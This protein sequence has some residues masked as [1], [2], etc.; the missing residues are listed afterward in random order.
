MD[1]QQRLIELRK[2]YD[3][4]MMDSEIAPIL[5]VSR[6]SVLLYRKELGLKTKFTYQ[7]RRKLK[8]EDFEELFKKGYSDY[9]IADI[10]GI[11]HCTVFEFR[12]KN[13]Y[14]RESLRENKAIKIKD[15]DI[16]FI[17]GTLMGDSSMRKTSKTSNASLVC[18]HSPKQ[19]ELTEYIANRL[20][21]LGTRFSYSKRSTPDK[22][23]GKL[24]EEYRVTT[25]ANPELNK[26]YDLFY[27]DGKRTIPDFFLEKFNTESLA[28]LFMDD[29]YKQEVSYSL[30]TMAYSMEDLERF[31]KM[32]KD[33]FNIEVSIHKDH[34]IR[35]KNSSRNLFENLVSP[36]ILDCCKYKLRVS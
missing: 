32:L 19:K 27:K 4:G 21:Y 8:K 30:A 16:P 1:K 14:E 3:E 35:I 11:D 18:S 12:K 22:R 7:D 29:G 6:A 34:R 15:G 28:W 10:L 33:K 24:Y 31:A 23:N 36:Y 20:S 17:I 5:G 13:G 25:K 26:F 2:L 9:K